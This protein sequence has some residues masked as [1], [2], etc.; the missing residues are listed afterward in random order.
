MEPKSISLARAYVG[1]QE[2]D[3]Q[4]RGHV[5]DCIMDGLN[6]PRGVSWCGAFVTWCLMRS[7]A[8]TKPDL[9][10]IL[11]FSSP[12][13]CDS[14]RDWLAQA[15]ALDMIVQQPEAGDLFVLLDSRGMAH[16][17]GFVTIPP[18]VIG[19]F[20][21]IEGNTNAG[22]SV[23][24]DGVYCRTRRA[25]DSVRFIRLPKELKAP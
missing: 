14:T 2:F 4:N 10:R 16:H 21:T 11:G 15:K 6:L 9:R 17:I 18:D 25:T 3:G 19:D 23:N 20:G 7:Y 13:Y 1:R 12:W 8:H 5:L 22:G 24:G